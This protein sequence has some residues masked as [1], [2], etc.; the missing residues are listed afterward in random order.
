VHEESLDEP[1]TGAPH[2]AVE[3]RASG[4]GREGIEKVAVGVAV[5]VP[6]AGKTGPSG[7]DGEGDDLAFGEG[8]LG[9]GGL[10]WRMRVAKVVDHNVECGEEGVHIDHEESVPFPWGSVSKPTLACGHLPLKFPMGNS[11][12]ALKSRECRAHHCDVERRCSW[13]VE[14]RALIC[15]SGCGM[16]RFH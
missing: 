14:E 15:V 3:L 8:G 9:A 5:E 4:Q 10:F 2:Q 7:E 11:H 16:P 12:Q 13:S 1:G 6:L